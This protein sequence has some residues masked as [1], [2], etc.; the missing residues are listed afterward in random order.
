[1]ELGPDADQY[2]RLHD[3]WLSNIHKLASLSPT[4]DAFK[5]AVEATAGTLARDAQ[6]QIVIVSPEK[7]YS[8][9]VDRSLLGTSDA[10]AFQR[11]ASS[12]DRAKL[13]TKFEVREGQEFSGDQKLESTLKHLHARQAEESLRT[14]KMLDLM[15]DTAPM[16]DPRQFATQVRREQSAAFETERNRY[17]LDHRAAQRIAEE[18][19]KQE[20]E[21]TLSQEFNSRL[22]R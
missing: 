16:K 10:G 19:N 13:P 8:T 1:M 4:G 3:H 20:R 15:H 2:A 22:Q 14:T 7:N 18:V 6:N 5:R 11:W 21:N 17:I 12:I 9:V